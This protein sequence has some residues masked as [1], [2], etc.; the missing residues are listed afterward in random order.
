MTKALTPRAPSPPVRANTMNT[1]A[2]DPLLIHCFDPVMSQPSPDAVARVRSAAVSDPAS[3][4][5]S[6]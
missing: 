4:S 5:V 1:S 3:G 6:A 2:I